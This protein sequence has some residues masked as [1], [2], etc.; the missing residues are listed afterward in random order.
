MLIA[1]AQSNI[2]S[3]KCTTTIDRLSPKPRLTHSPG[4]QANSVRNRHCMP[5][6]LNGLDVIKLV[7]TGNIS[8]TRFIKALECKDNSVQSGPAEAGIQ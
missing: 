6:L 8:A 2:Y 7:D 5:S 4:S 1:C 3:A